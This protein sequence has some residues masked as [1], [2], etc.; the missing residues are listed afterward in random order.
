MNE[1]VSN[2]RF[3]CYRPAILPK[4]LTC[5][6]KSLKVRYYQETPIAAASK[7]QW[8]IENTIGLSKPLKIQICFLCNVM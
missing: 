4:L 5:L 6:F 3:P 7:S 1:K 8:I 2:N